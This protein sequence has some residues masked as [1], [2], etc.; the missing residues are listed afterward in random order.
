[1]S[2]RTL[3]YPCVLLA[4]VPPLHSQKIEPTIAITNVNVLP[5]TSDV[6]LRDQTVVIEDGRIAKIGPATQVPVPREAFRVDGSASYLLP[7]MIDA[8]VH[9]YAPEQLALYIAKGVT[10]VFNLNGRPLH[11]SWREQVASGKR[12]GPRIYT[13]GPKFD[14]A[15][16]PEKAVELVDQYWKQGYDGIKIYNQVSKAEYPALIAQAKK[17]HMLIVGHIARE[18]GFEATVGAGQ[19]IA[20][21][22]E[23]LYTFFEEHKKNGAPDPAFIPEAVTLT[24]ASGVPVIATLVTYEHIIEQATDLQAFL[25]RPETDYLAQWEVADLKEPTQNPYLNFDKDGIAELR[26][27]YPFQQKLV[28]ALHDAKVPIL[29]GTDS[30]AGTSV[31]GFSLHEELEILVRSGLSPFE[32]LKSATVTAAQFLRGSDEFGTVEEGKAADLILLRANPLDDIANTKQVAGVAVRGTWFG[33]SELDRMLQHVPFSYA[34]DEEVAK[35]KFRESPE[36]ALAFLKQIDPFF[37]LGS[38][39]VTQAALRDGIARFEPL[40]HRIDES[41]PDSPLGNPELL[42]DIADYLLAKKRTEDAI[43]LYR[44][45]ITEHPK[46]AIA[47]DRF[48]RAYYKLGEHELSLK[49]YQEALKVDPNY[50]NAGTAKRRIAE[51]TSK[52]AGR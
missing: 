40:I 1:M 2:L 47:F 19:A 42:S 33:Q 16:P 18:P 12:L 25:T 3:L 44:F 27:N 22:E 49:Y 9:L 30:G 17:R 36:E 7:G 43:E 26:R 38:A 10:T 23:Y 39:V 31:P 32:A 11:L 13:V 35:E 28:K 21:A 45:N 46:A 6:V 8:H 15:D 34:R 4:V 52:P 20:H 29:V 50:W 41:D 48:A 5:M 51:I 24:K 37:E 14:R